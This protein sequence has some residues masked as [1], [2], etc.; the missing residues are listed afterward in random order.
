MV[1]P[2]PPPLQTGLV[3][4]V[5]AYVAWVLLGSAERGGGPG[6]STIAEALHLPVTDVTVLAPLADG[7]DTDVRITM[8]ATG[9]GRT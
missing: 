7:D 6:I 5:I 4:E 3:D 2:W 9:T 1:R 8:T